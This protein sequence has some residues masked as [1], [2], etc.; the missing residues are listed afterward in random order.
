MEA[1][2]FE[3]FVADHFG[4]THT[5]SV[6]RKTFLELGGYPAGRKVCEDVHFLIRLC[7]RSKRVGVICEPLGVY[8]IHSQSATRRDPLAAQ[9]SNVETL[10]SLKEEAEGLPVSIRRGYYLRLQNARLNLAYALL[11]RGQRGDAIKAVLPSVFE[12]PGAASLRGLV[13][14]IRGFGRDA[15][16]PR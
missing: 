3:P 6:P 9:V 16:D 1:D 15:H 2:E 14:V 4:D 12:N 7:A 5:L 10:V 13:S 8:L 11:R